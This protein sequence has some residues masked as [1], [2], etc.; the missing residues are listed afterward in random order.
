MPETPEIV[1]L[2]SL[3]PLREWFNAGRGRVRFLALL[4]PT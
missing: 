3:A 2:D 4:S 1:V